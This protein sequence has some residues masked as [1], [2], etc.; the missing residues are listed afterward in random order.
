MFLRYF[1]MRASWFACAALAVAVLAGCGPD[2]TTG[3]TD[4]PPPTEPAMLSFALGDYADPLGVYVDTVRVGVIDH[5]S[6]L[7]VDVEPGPHDVHVVN[8][9]TQCVSKSQSV[10]AESGKT[11]TVE[12][13]ADSPPDWASCPDSRLC[14][15]LS[16][17]SEDLELE[18]NGHWVGSISVGSS[19]CEIVD[20]GEQRFRFRNDDGCVSQSF[21]RTIGLAATDTVRVGAGGLSI[22]WVVCPPTQL[23]FSGS[24]TYDVFVDDRSIGRLSGNPR[25]EVTPGTHRW[26]V[27]DPGCGLMSRSKT[28]TVD[29]YQTKTIQVRSADISYSPPTP[30]NVRASNG[31]YSSYVRVTW[32]SVSP[33]PARYAIYRDGSRLA[34]TTGTSYDDRSSSTSRTYSYSVRA[35]WS[36]D[37]SSRSASDTG[38]RKKARFYNVRAEPDNPNQRLYVRGKLDMWGYRNQCKAQAVW[39]F[40]PSGG[41]YY[42]VRTPCSLNRWGYIGS[43]FDDSCPASDRTTFD[44]WA[45]ISYSCFTDR[46]GEYCAQVKLYDSASISHPNDTTVARSVYVCVRWTSA[47]GGSGEPVAEVR[48]LDDDEARRLEASIARAGGIQPAIDAAPVTDAVPV[49]QE[50]TMSR[51]VTP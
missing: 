36:C 49:D 6:D 19:R 20:V 3:V 46:T 12:F 42:Y 48:I 29:R 27:R 50:S 32:S 5:E 14:F 9:R 17:L 8:A 35:E 43:I 22:D 47:R 24:G 38:F 21:T 23:S 15:T 51:E 30:T 16:G 28:V 39:W 1:G 31:T 2:D 33:R 13:D 45:W 40:R 11:V 7:D 37:Q 34:T 41:S 18:L 25:I 4:P 10:V 44:F 26:T